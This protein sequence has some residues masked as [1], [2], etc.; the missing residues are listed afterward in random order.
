M[1]NIDY[2]K[3]KTIGEALEVKEKMGPDACFIAG[4]TDVLVLAR[5]RKLGCQALISLRRIPE[6]AGITI[7]DDVLHLGPAT[8]LTD[9]LQSPEVARELPIL[10]DAVQ[11]M[12]STQMRNM[13][14]VGGN[15]MT[16]ASSG[17]TLGPLLCLDAV[18]RLVSSRGER[19]VPMDEMFVGPRTTAAEP[20]EL[21][22]GLEI[23]LP[24]AGGAVSSGAFFKLTRRAAMDLALINVSVQLWVSPDRATIAKA[25]MAAGVAAPTPIRLKETEEELAGQPVAEAVK[26]QVA[27]RAIGRE[28]RLR[29]SD[30][31]SAWYREE[32]LRV[33]IPR[34]AGLALQRMDIAV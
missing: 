20:D 7:Q 13:A 12:G 11:V 15:V 23:P 29:D 5:D 18:C 1:K 34:A 4:G 27:I 19:R 14:T 24:K 8:T 9:I 3:P 25:R 30:R 17:D 2:Y 10:H 21:L 33:L 28:C 26:E 16:A 31:C 22:A 6:L 32:M